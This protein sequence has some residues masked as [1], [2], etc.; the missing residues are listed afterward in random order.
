MIIFGWITMKIKISRRKSPPV[1]GSQKSGGEWKAIANKL[2][3]VTDT[4]YTPRAIFGISLSPH[5]NATR[6]G[7]RKLNDKTSAH[8]HKLLHQK[9][10][11]SNN[12]L[13][14][15]SYLKFF[16]SLDFLILMLLK[17]RHEKDFIHSLCRCL[18][19]AAN[20]KWTAINETQMLLSW[21]NRKY[22]PIP[23]AIGHGHD[24]TQ[25]S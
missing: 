18:Q 15:T 5:N 21:K 2:P 25:S 20:R 8:S 22:V 16:F 3:S 24:E 14:P 9:I 4:I 10:W 19:N 7:W 23:K 13:N 6:R 1:P 11:T 17:L 12:S